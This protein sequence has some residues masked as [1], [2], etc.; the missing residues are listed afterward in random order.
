[1]TGG[2]LFSL[3][4]ATLIALAVWWLE[5]IIHSVQKKEP[6]GGSN[7]PDFYLENPV[8]HQYDRMGNLA[9]QV[10]GQSMIQY[11]GEDSTE[12][13]KIHLQQFPR[14]GSYI[15]MTADQ[16]RLLEG[17]KKILLTDNIHIHRPR[18][19]IN[20]LLDI[21]AENLSID[22]T[23]GYMETAGLVTIKTSKHEVSGI[24]M[25]AWTKAGKYYLQSQARGRHEP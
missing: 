18:G 16:G 24:G 23:S 11:L 15:T 2:H 20:D 1:M 4:S 5:D 17:G 7:R 10:R 25:Q 21:T 13:V 19:K 22:Q 9:Y 14:S 3:A 6:Y 8:L 12:V